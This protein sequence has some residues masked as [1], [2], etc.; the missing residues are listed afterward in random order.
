MKHRTD[1][2]TICM[3]PGHNASQCPAER[4]PRT[5]LKWVLAALGCIALS[6]LPVWMTKP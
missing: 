5:V 3:Q 6:W 4:W 1:T 2:C